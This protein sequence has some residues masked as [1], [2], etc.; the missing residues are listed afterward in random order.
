M[1]CY[2]EMNAQIVAL[3][4]GFNNPACDYAAERIVELEA[5]LQE[6]NDNLNF[7]TQRLDVRQFEVADL[8][9]QLKQVREKLQTLKT[10]PVYTNEDLVREY[11]Q[12]KEIAD[13]QITFISLREA[14]QTYHPREGAW[15]SQCPLCA[16]CTDYGPITH[17]ELCP[18]KL[19]STPQ[20]F[21]KE[22]CKR[23]VLE[24]FIEPVEEVV[25]IHADPDSPDYNECDKPGEQCHWCDLA[26]EALTLARAELSEEKP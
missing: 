18:F 9:Q 16:A 17:K 20:Q 5:Q 23:S 25:R 12:R 13:L 11:E 2:P 10:S 26:K 4:K 1:T 19:A 7:V 22:W 3:L 21:R 15:D 8:Q 6:A 24:K 14:L